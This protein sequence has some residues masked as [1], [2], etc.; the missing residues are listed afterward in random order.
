MTGRLMHYSDEPV[1]L[2][3]SRE[4]EQEAGSVHT[5]PRGLWVSVEGED[6]WPS[7]CRAEEFRLDC[8]RVE[9]E[10]VLRPT[11]RI[12][13]L[14]SR[15]AL[16]GFQTKYGV[17]E[18]HTYAAHTWADVHSWVD[19]WI[20]WRRVAQDA[21]G[22]VI[23]PYQWPVRLTLSW[24]YSWD[25]ASGCIWNLDAIASLTVTAEREPVAP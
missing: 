5:K 2:D 9:H 23:A 14:G 10:I 3:R 24:Y 13:R 4:Y 12:I 1:I 22:I 7:W 21:D 18:A 19:T 16:Y 17:G 11:A 8:L 25:V 20:D 6:D 15:E